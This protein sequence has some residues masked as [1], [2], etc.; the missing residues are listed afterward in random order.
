MTHQIGDFSLE[1]YKAALEADRIA[2]RGSD[3]PRGVFKFTCPER[4]SPFPFAVISNSRRLRAPLRIAQPM[5]DD[6]LP[7]ARR[8][9][10]VRNGGSKSVYRSGNFHLCF[11]AARY[12]PCL[13]LLVKTSRV[14]EYLLLVLNN[15]SYVTYAIIIISN[16][17]YSVKEG[18][19]FSPHFSED[20]YKKM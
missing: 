2:C 17:F 1:R 11:F 12:L 10:D 3:A 4:K 19:E 6:L 18:N 20:L 14:A 7:R 5:P 13:C 15:F 16:R 9:R 8:K